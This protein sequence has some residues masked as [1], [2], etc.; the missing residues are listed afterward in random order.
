MLMPICNV[1]AVNNKIILV[2]PISNDNFLKPKEAKANVSA[3]LQ[4]Y[5]DIMEK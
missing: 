5:Y 1:V 3:Y 4:E 2:Y